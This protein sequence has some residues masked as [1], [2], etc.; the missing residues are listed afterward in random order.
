MKISLRAIA[1]PAL[2][3]LGVAYGAGPSAHAAEPQTDARA[4]IESMSESMLA[5]LRAGADRLTREANFRAMYRRFFDN[6]GTAAFAI[7]SALQEA[8]PLQRRQALQAFEDYVVAVYSA[9]LVDFSGVKLIVRGCEPMD[10][11]VVV[12]TLLISPNPRGEDL[13]VKWRLVQLGGQLKVRDVIVDKISLM[14]TARRAFSRWL[15]ERGGT[16]EGL[17]GKLREQ[18]AEVPKS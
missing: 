4:I 11:G 16:L 1:S 12:T 2:I 9:K 13:E 18:I 17:I 8:A 5:T 6:A 10:N 3:T 15:G 7:G 14:L